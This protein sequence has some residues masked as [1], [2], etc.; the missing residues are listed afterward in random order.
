MPTD[1]KTQKADDV[2]PKPA[3]AEKQET[4]ELSDDELGA[5]SGGMGIIGPTGPIDPGGGC[6]TQF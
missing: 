3:P 6:F 2:P 4:E 1:D 5:V